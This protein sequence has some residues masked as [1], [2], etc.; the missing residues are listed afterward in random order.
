M[1]EALLFSMEQDY[2]I[3][4]GLDEAGRGPLAGPVV[5]SAVVLGPDFPIHLLNDSKKLSEKQRLE[6]EKVI[7]EKALFWAIALATAQEID[8]INILQAS[9]LAMQRAYEKIS[10]KIQVDLAF[11]DG[12]Q[13]PNLDCITQTIVGG[14]ALV[15]QIMAASIL[16]KNQRDRYMVQSHAKWPYYNFAKHKGYPTAEHREACL[17]YGLSPIHR[18]SF[19][20]EQKPTSTQKQATLF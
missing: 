14:D 1:Q 16:A 11:V 10:R 17:L 15:P 6:A 3:V 7:K 2:R 12:N 4:C 19:H 5:A 13:R 18:R 20:I 9:L 8:R